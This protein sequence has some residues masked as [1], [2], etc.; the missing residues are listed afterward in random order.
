LESFLAQVVSQRMRKHS[1]DAAN[2]ALLAATGSGDRLDAVTVIKLRPEQSDEMAMVFQTY[3]TNGTLSF[4]LEATNEALPEGLANMRVVSAQAFVPALLM[5]EEGD[6][7]H[8]EVWLQKLGVSTCSSVSGE[9]RLFSHSSTGY[10]SV[11]SARE[12]PRLTDQPPRW[13]TK[14][15]QDTGSEVQ[16][17][18]S[19]PPSRYQLCAL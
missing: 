3:W 5:T 1:E 11:Y 14:P 18:S 10:F 12:D 16:G 19:G 8:A 6:N 13:L 9:Q 7:E 2:R 17:D 4:N 15:T